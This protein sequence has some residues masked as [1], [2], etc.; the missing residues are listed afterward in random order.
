MVFD[1]TNIQGVLGGGEPAGFTLDRPTFITA[2]RTYHWNRGRG[3]PEATWIR[4][5]GAQE[6]QFKAQAENPPTWWKAAP[7]LLLQP[8]R[9]LIEDGDPDTWA[10]NPGSGGKGFVRIFGKPVER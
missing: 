10:R 5:R 2:I 4:L 9:Y 3:M 1:N 7:M 6:E 8:G